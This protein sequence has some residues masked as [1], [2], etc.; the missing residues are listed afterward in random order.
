MEVLP[1]KDETISLRLPHALG[2]GRLFLVT[3]PTLER[4]RGDGGTGRG[5]KYLSFSLVVI[6]VFSVKEVAEVAR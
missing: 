5:D 3:P 1:S 4:R 2:L 6:V